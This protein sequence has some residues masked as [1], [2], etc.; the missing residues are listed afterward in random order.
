MK[1]AIFKLGLLILLQIPF[2]LLAQQGNWQGKGGRGEGKPS[3]VIIKGKV[4]TESNKPLEFA[5]VSLH[6]HRDSSLINGGY[7]N[8]KG[9]FRME[10]RPGRF[11]LIVD[12]LSY[13]QKVI[14]MIKVKPGTP[15]VDLGIIILSENTTT[16]DE[17]EVRAERSSMELKLDKRVF[18]VGK[19]LVNAGSNAAEILDN[20]PSVEVDI[21]GNVS[22]RGSENVR[23]LIDGKPSGLVSTSSTEALKQMQ[24]DMVKSVEVITNPSAKFDAEGE[25]GIINIVLKKEK[26]KGV[27]GTFGLTA[28][29]PENFGARY[30]LN[31]RRDKINFFSNFG[32]RYR[33]NPGGGTYFQETIIDDVLYKYN[34]ESKH[35]RGGAGGNI[36]VGMDYYINETNT[37][38]GSVLYRHNNGDNDAKTTYFDLDSN[39]NL[40]NTTVRDVDENEKKNVIETNLSYQKTFGHRKHK[41]TADFT[42]YQNDDTEIADYIE[43]TDIE[44]TPDIFQASTNTEDQINYMFQS[45]YTRPIGKDGKFETGIKGNIRSIVNDFQVQQRTENSE[46]EILQNFNN[47]LRYSENIYAAYAM[48]GNK[49][50]E[51]GYQLGLRSE[52]SDIKTELLETNE[53]NPRDYLDFFPTVHLTYKLTEKDQVQLS[54]SRRISRPRFWYLLPFFTFN[55]V[56]NRFSGNPDLD[57]EYTNSFEAGYLKYFEKGTLLSSIYYRYRTGLIERVRIVQ[58]D[59][60]TDL[61][62]I[63]L[64][65]E[66]NFGLEFSFSYD[67]TKWWKANANFN[68]FRAIRQGEYEGQILESDAYRWNSRLNSRMNFAKDFTF[69][70]SFRYRSPGITTQGRSLSI[71]NWDAGISKDIFK[72]KGTLTLS[73]KDI[74]NT[75]KRRSITELPGFYAESEFQW[76]SRT[77][78]LDFTYRLNQK[79]SRRPQRGSWD[80]GDGGF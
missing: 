57:P 38:T 63:N 64:A 73:A 10:N 11:Y 36:Q 66:N 15:V 67:L 3:P 80:G 46:F 52:Y 26:K 31:F 27:N 8:E 76:R 51:F 33:R 40:L 56:R 59:G 12:F 24:G 77:V 47:E 21:D 37:L 16:L 19:D 6:S 30:S 43:T 45:D 75:R 50:K 5:T 72:G 62:P 29:W 39:D 9:E 49:Y 68:F 7:T 18:N 69:Q 41:L 53:S 23:I 20:V 74:L 60:T 22:L 79:K 13:T 55:D 70:T 32:I 44:N 48:Y 2:F 78:V 71:Y 35:I 34:T 58:N 25:V 1:L 28:G 65:E 14:P 4:F 42:Y 54:Y 17:V 61:F